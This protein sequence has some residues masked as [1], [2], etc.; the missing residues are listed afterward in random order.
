[1]ATL[2]ATLTLSSS[3]A[4]SDILNLTATDALTVT[5]PAIGMSKV[6][7]TTTGGDTVI[8]PDVDSVKYIFIKHT[9]LDASDAT[10]TDTALV[11]DTDNVQIANL[12]PGEWLF[13]PHSKGAAKGVQIQASANTV[14]VEYAY[15][16]K[17]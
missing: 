6:A 3:D 4:T 12:A 11:E 5:D 8:A 17:G 15:W 9:G 16:T 14:L 7:A 10:T 13:M 1:M 2:N